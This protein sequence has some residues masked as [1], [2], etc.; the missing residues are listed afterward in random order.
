MS[1]YVART[2]ASNQDAQEEITS[3]HH[4][5]NLGP[6]CFGA[7]ILEEK[8]LDKFKP[9]PKVEKYVGTEN[10]MTWLDS[11]Q[12]AMSI[13][14]YD[15]LIMDYWSHS[16]LE[17]HAIYGFKDCRTK[18]S[19]HGVTY[20]NSSSE[21]LGELTNVRP[22]VATLGSVSKVRVSRTTHIWQCGPSCTTHP[23]ML[24]RNL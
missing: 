8:F 24:V 16:W 22:L 5:A 12:L 14:N 1:N 3:H 13:Q 19:P 9:P 4:W 18:A 2:S 6:K 15:W 7:N 17:E 23:L 11:Y 10:P 20:K 21:T